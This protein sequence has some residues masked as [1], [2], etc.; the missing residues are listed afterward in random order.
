MR[1]LLVFIKNTKQNGQPSRRKRHAYSGSSLPDLAMPDTDAGQ[2]TRDLDR[3]D[4]EAPQMSSILRASGEVRDWGKPRAREAGTPTVHGASTPH[5]RYKREAGLEEQQED[6]STELHYHRMAGE[7]AGDLA[8]QLHWDAEHILWFAYGAYLGDGDFQVYIL[9]ADKTLS[10][11][12]ATSA[13]LTAAV[14]QLVQAFQQGEI[15]VSA[16]GKNL[17]LGVLSSCEDLKCQQVSLNV[18]APDP[19]TTRVFTGTA[20]PPTSMAC[21]SAMTWVHATLVVI[22]AVAA[23]FGF[24]SW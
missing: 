3:S 21:A 8:R 19:T 13:N 17:D 16:G 1:S 2:S 10:S 24:F 5:R 18:S 12:N 15:T 14:E 11:P 20:S 9:L 4:K 6:S 22:S 7:V 23:P